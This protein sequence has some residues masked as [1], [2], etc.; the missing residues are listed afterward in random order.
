MKEG[1]KYVVVVVVIV[2]PAEKKFTFKAMLVVFMDIEMCR[3][4]NFKV[5]CEI[6]IHSYHKGR[7]DIALPLQPHISFP[8]EQAAI[9][10]CG[11][12][13]RDFDYSRT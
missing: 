9:A 6:K 2:R 13:I 12:A 1:V 7:I 5:C 8:T 10:I 4:F 11:F 3:T